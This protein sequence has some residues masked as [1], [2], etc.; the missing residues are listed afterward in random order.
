MLN[1]VIVEGVVSI[2]PTN[3]GYFTID[4]SRVKGGEIDTNIACKLPGSV[5]RDDIKCS[6]IVRIVGH[7]GR[8]DELNISLGVYIEQIEVTYIKDGKYK[9]RKENK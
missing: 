7:L 8:F 6:N 4:T 1:S 9:F 3:R 5:N 2:S